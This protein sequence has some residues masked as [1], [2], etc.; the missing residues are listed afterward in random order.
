MA[1]SDWSDDASGDYY[2]LDEDQ[3]D[4]DTESRVQ[5]R[6]STRNVTRTH[7]EKTRK[8]GDRSEHRGS[9][10]P[11]TNMSLDEKSEEEESDSKAEDLDTT[12]T[13]DVSEQDTTA[14]KSQTDANDDVIMNDSASHNRK[15]R[16]KQAGSASTVSRVSRRSTIR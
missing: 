8:N 1:C 9:R 11:E 3:S 13:H 6:K 15:L 2:Y 7:H 10:K 12:T 5:N 16:R 4:S 14:S